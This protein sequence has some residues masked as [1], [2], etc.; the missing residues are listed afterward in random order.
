MLEVLS[1]HAIAEFSNGDI[2][3]IPALLQGE[4]WGTLIFTNKDK[5]Q[6]ITFD[7]ADVESVDTLIKALE[8]VKDLMTDEHLIGD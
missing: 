3:M 5:K 2:L 6:S 8:E 7:F 4:Q 1:N